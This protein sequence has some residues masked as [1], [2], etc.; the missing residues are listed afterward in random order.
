MDQCL[1]EN[2]SSFGWVGDK[3][4]VFGDISDV[5]KKKKKCPLSSPMAAMLQLSE[6]Q[7]PPPIVVWT[8]LQTP[9]ISQ[10][11]DKCINSSVL[12]ELQENLSLQ[13]QRFANTDVC[14]RALYK[15]R[16]RCA[17]QPGVGLCLIWGILVAF[18][19]VF[20][21]RGLL[22]SHLPCSWSRFWMV[23]KW[24]KK[25]QAKKCQCMLF[26]SDCLHIK[27]KKEKLKKVTQNQY[28]HSE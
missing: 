22:V 5:K 15:H 8:L 21:L 7:A 3:S 6:T 17:R 11:K 26:S 12:L 10:P 9:T 1:S 18:R 2:F 27:R 23:H 19:Q 28:S 16:Y 24:G 14:G 20:M 13:T 25:C 4:H